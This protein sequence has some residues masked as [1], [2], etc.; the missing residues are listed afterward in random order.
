MKFLAKLFAFLGIFLI[1]VGIVYGFMT[2]FN[3]WAGFP[4]ILATAVMCLFLA[5]FMW[6]TDKKHPG[7]PYEDLDGE[8]SQAAGN[9]GFYSPWSWWPLVLGVVCMLL[10]IGLAV[11]QLWVA[12]LAVVL[13]ILACVGWV[14]EYNRG[15]HAH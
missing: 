14:Y 4:A 3:E 5:F 2:Q 11:G 12:G 7:M 9:Y 13:T 15:D 8:I 1:P 10:V 6:T